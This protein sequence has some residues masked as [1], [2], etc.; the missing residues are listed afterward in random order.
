MIQKWTRS[1]N[2]VF[3]S[4]IS[5][6]KCRNLKYQS[7]KM[8][9]IYLIGKFTGE[10]IL[11]IK[12]NEFCLF[13]KLIYRVCHLRIEK[14]LRR[15][16]DWR[17]GERNSLGRYQSQVVWEWK[18]Q[19]YVESQRTFYQGTRDPHLEMNKDECWTSCLVQEVFMSVHCLA[20]LMLFRTWWDSQI[21]R[22]VCLL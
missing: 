6:W 5:N 14:P 9:P 18:K 2:L 19:G 3:K 12:L 17:K 13:G 10:P 22:S 4:K 1:K 20:Y 16:C 11:I 8:K 7:C 21:D 15:A